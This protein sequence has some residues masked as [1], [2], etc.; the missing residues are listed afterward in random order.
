MV[1]YDLAALSADLQAP[2]CKHCPERV[3][4]NKNLQDG[5]GHGKVCLINTLLIARFLGF[6]ACVAA[7]WQPSPF[8]H[9]EK[10]KL[11]WTLNA[12]LGFSNERCRVLG[13]KNVETCR[14]KLGRRVTH[15]HDGPCCLSWNISRCLPQTQQWI[16]SNEGKESSLFEFQMQWCVYILQN[17]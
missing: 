14:T 10:W 4:I 15:V 2:P 9:R 13:I 12:G 8:Q 11:S 17:I 6:C 5:N 3:G 16:S 1:Q 7:Q